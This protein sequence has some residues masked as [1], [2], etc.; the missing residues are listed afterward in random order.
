MRGSNGNSPVGLWLSG[1][2][3]ELAFG[4]CIVEFSIRK[5]MTDHEGNMQ[6]GLFPLFAIQTLFL[7]K[8]DLQTPVSQ[9]HCEIFESVA[10][11]QTLTVSLEKS[12]PES[13]SAKFF[14]QASHLV[15]VVLL[16]VE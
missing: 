13:Y 16:S 10:L 11:R 5:E 2:E 14:N 3:K 9:I 7:L 6:Q 12:T 8:P 15:A 1:K 4:E